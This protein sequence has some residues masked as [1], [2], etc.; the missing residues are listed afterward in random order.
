MPG[1]MV[2]APS[3]R[4]VGTGGSAVLPE[5]IATLRARTKSRLN[6]GKQQTIVPAMGKIVPPS[7]AEEQC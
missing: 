2:V 7:A 5:L 1:G 6:M 3:D 4:R